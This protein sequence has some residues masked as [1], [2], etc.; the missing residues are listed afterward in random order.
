MTPPTSP[1]RHRERDDTGPE[2]LRRYAQICAPLVWKFNVPKSDDNEACTHAVLCEFARRR[3][4]DQA[5][6][7]PL[8]VYTEGSFAPARRPSAS[9]VCS[10]VTGLEYIPPY[11]TTRD[12]LP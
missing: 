2:G 6:V 3:Y 8:P 11:M 5:V 9:T 1:V 12:Q 7:P 10:T 4:G